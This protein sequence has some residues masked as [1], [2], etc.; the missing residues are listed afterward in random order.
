MSV[1]CS[2]CEI[3]VY[4]V[5]LTVQGFGSEQKEFK[6]L[7]HDGAFWFRVGGFGVRVQGSRMRVEVC[8]FSVQCSGIRG[9]GPEFGVRGLGCRVGGF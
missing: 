4:G 7:L 3:G 8:G 9:Q 1:W 6:E 5:G 2:M